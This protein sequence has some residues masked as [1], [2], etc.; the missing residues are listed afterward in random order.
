MEKIY[1]SIQFSKPNSW[2]YGFNEWLFVVTLI[3]R[4]C[5]LKLM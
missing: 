3:Q 1:I 2:N 4:Q 5:S